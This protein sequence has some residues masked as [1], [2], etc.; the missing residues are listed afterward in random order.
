[1]RTRTVS[2]F[3]LCLSAGLVSAASATG[4]CF[5]DKFGFEWNVDRRSGTGTVE[6]GTCGATPIIW[7]VS[8]TITKTARREYDVDLTA[9]D[10]HGEC[11]SCVGS[12]IYTGHFS[13]RRGS[14]S[15]VADVYDTCPGG[16]DTG[17]WTARKH[18]CS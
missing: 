12:I 11:E 7:S 13:R 10:S 6:V 17:N 9:T 3:V 16:T 15:W 1:M 14:G 18:S 4:F 2:L 8:G 5:R